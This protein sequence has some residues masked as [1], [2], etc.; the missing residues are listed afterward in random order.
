MYSRKRRQYSL[1]RPHKRSPMPSHP[2]PRSLGARPAG[3][4]F[5]PAASADAAQHGANGSRST[6]SASPRPRSLRALALFIIAIVPLSVGIWALSIAVPVA[7]EAREAMGDIFVTPVDRPHLDGLQPS[8]PAVPSSATGASAS[9]ATSDEVYGDASPS[10]EFTSTPTPGP[11]ATLEPAGPT[12]TP[13]PEWDGNDPVHILLLGVDSRPD[14][15]DPPRSDTIIVV[16]VD[17]GE[18][19]VDMFSVPRDLLVEIPGYLAQKVNAAYVIGETDELPGGGA[20]LAAQTIEYNFGVRI[21]Y[22]ATVDVTGMERVVDEIGGIVVDVK[23]PI[24]DDQYPTEDYRYTRVYF[25]TGPQEMDGVQAVRY[26]RTRHDDNDFK[27][28]QRQQEVLLAIRNQ[29]LVSGVITKLP[30]LISE[31]GDSVRTDLS[32]RQ[33]LSLARF[34]QDLPRDRIFSHS[35]NGLLYEE[36]IDQEFFFVADWSS[37]RNLVQNLPENIDAS[38][39]PGSGPPGTTFPEEPEDVVVP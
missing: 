29:V 2:L 19:R 1:G 20:V 22:W 10:P 36:Y 37:V 26:A 34:G 35:I 9:T 3:D 8:P 15:E 38:N 23:A 17:P 7:I 27:R 4:A 12:A 31:V 39:N 21:D 18:E 13:Y 5:V 16:R 25:A 30:Q 11:D 6:A 14:D 28:S 24:K 33:V 32:P